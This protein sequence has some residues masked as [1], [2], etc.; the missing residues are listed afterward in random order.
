MWSAAV[1][2]QLRY[3]LTPRTMPLS[4]SGELAV[5]SASV[6]VRMRAGSRLLWDPSVLD[7]GALG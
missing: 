7:A 1:V 3:V 2:R 6:T 4:V 5:S